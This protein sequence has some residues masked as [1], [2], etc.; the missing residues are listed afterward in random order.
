MQRN[1]YVKKQNG[2]Y[3]PAGYCPTRQSATQ[4]NGN[5]KQ[6]TLI[7]H[8]NNYEFRRTVSTS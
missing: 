6:A 1:N 5:S 7:I 8:R 3:G 2:S 4:G